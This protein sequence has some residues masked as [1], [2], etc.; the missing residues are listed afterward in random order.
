LTPQIAESAV[1]QLDHY[2]QVRFPD[3]ASHCIAIGPL[4][5]M[6]YLPNIQEQGPDIAAKAETLR[7]QKPDGVLIVVGHV[8]GE[9]AGSQFGR[10]VRQRVDQHPTD[11]APPPRRVNAHIAIA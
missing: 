4:R 3:V 7:Q 2:R 8:Y 9:I 6:K 11:P 1:A 5:S 10:L